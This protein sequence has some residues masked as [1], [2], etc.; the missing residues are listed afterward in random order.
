MQGLELYIKNFSWVFAE[1]VIRITTSFITNILIINYIGAEIFGKISF[2]QAVVSFLMGMSIL[3]LKDL[4]TSKLVQEKYNTNSIL[5]TA[6]FLRLMAGI[7][8]SLILIKL[9]YFLYKD[10][11]FILF[12]LAVLSSSLIFQSFSVV[13]S[14]FQ[15]NKLQK[16]AA[17]TLFVQNIFITIL[18]LVFI[19]LAIKAKYVLFIYFFEYLILSLIYL[20]FSIKLNLK[21]TPRFFSINLAKSLLS[22][23]APLILSSITVSIYMNIDMVMITSIV[24]PN[25]AGIYAAATTITGLLYF[26]PTILIATAYPAISNYNQERNIQ[27]Q[28]MNLLLRLSSLFGFFVSVSIFLLSNTIISILYTPEFINSSDV[29]MIHIFCFPFVF[30]SMVTNMYLISHNLTKIIFYRSFL[31]MII[32]IIFN[33]ILIKEYGAKGAA[34][35]T[36]I[37]HIIVSLLIDLFNSETRQFFYTKLSI[38]N[39]FKIKK[40][41]FF[42]LE[43]LNINIRSLKL[44]KTYSFI[45]KYNT[46]PIFIKPNKFFSQL[47]EATFISS[48][49]F[50][51]LSHFKDP[52]QVSSSASVELNLKKLKDNQIIYICSDAIGAFVN[53]YLHKINKPFILMTGDSDLLINEATIEKDILKNIVTNK[54][55]VAWYAQNLDFNHRKA[56]HLPIGMDYHTA[57]ENPSF[58]ES[59]RL[60]PFEQ[61]KEIVEIS[62]NADFILNRELK[63][64]S[65]WHFFMDRGDRKDCFESIDK[66]ICF[67]EPKR[68]KRSTSY[69]NQS[70]YAFT[71]SPSGEG[72]DCHRTFEAILLGSIPI[73]KSNSISHMFKDLPVCIVDK[74]SD[75]SKEFLTETLDIYL[76]KKFDYKLIF[77][78]HWKNILGFEEVAKERSYIFTMRQFRDF[79]NENIKR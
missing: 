62:N 58:F 47:P 60:L 25:S 16:Y 70:N 12:A 42:I 34:A 37:T 49:S 56:K 39:I 40:D 14:Y 45:K 33:F 68:V 43:N 50:I 38:F 1:K 17:L 61:E 64:Y 35:A 24:G 4:V 9:S 27:I 74:W 54:Y 65:N 77:N 73:V 59:K 36:L 26:V 28:R 11:G 53:K 75:V 55:L 22:L 72:F 5:S 21:I 10:E 78:N 30:M 3:G 66:Q 18:K 71:S 7:I 48:K 51:N 76:S 29:L 79:L 6:F 15:A 19:Y 31:G 46:L 69:I 8:C 32:N 20:Y 44:Y 23:S 52:F 67:Y 13:E 41:I 63:I 2:A 57:Y